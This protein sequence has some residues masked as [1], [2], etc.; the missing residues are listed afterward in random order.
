MSTTYK[1]YSPD[2]NADVSEQYSY[3]LFH[4]NYYYK[5][6]NKIS[7]IKE[8]QQRCIELSKTAPSFIENPKPE[9]VESIIMEQL[10]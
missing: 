7:S 6:I 1:C 2:C 5:S 10:F 4:Q 9:T 8:I 3:C